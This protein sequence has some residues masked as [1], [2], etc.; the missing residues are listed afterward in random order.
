MKKKKTGLIITIVV[1]A[2]ILVVVGALAV[3]YF[4]TDMFKSEQELFWKYVSKNAQIT[5]V[6]S[7]EN[8][9]SQRQWK[10]NNSYTSQG[11]LSLSVIKEN[12]TQEIKVGTTAMHNQANGRTYSDA[13][14]YNGDE[15][16]LKLSY[17]NSG[18]V[19]ALQCK[20]IYEPYYIGVR[21]SNLK[22]FATNMGLSEEEIE[23]IPDSIP[24]N[25]T[26]NASK[27]TE[28]ESKYLSDTY[29][30]VLMNTIAK[31]RYV[32]VEK[33]NIIV[34]SQNYEAAGYQLTLTSDDLEQM[35]INV[36]TKAKDD[37]QTIAILNKLV[38]DEN[39]TEQINVQELIE[40][41]LE[42]IQ[43]DD[44]SV[45]LND[46]IGFVEE[47]LNDGIELIDEDL[48]DGIEPIDEDSNDMSEEVPET[49]DET[50]ETI[51]IVS[52][53]HVGD[54]I[55]KT[56]I[57]CVNE[58]ELTVD[59]DKSQENKKFA[60]IYGK[61]IEDAES[62]EEP[63]TMQLTM[64]KQNLSNMVTY[65]TS[66]IN[67]QN[68]YKIIMTTSLG[69]VIENKIENNSK[70]TILDNNKKIEASYYKTMQ[71]AS[72]DVEIQELTNSNAVIIN[73]Y[74]KD[75]LEN[76]FESL[77]DKSEQVLTSKME[78]LNIGLEDSDDSLYYIEGIT[79]SL[80]TVANANGVA[81]PV[82][83]VGVS[84]VAAINQIMQSMTET[85]TDAS[86][87]LEDTKIDTI[88]EIM[89]LT[90]SIIQFDSMAGEDFSNVDN[91]KTLLEE[92]FGDGYE[93][94]DLGN[95]SFNNTTKQL[96]GTITVKT[97]EKL[98]LV[99]FTNDTVVETVK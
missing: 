97:D 26:E 74:P 78:Q 8:E 94:T 69:N 71:Q 16:L 89:Q 43:S 55:F 31:E 81:Q 3:L 14:L 77:G 2:V 9:E 96:E 72:Q 25:V 4:M 12:G 19:Y 48:D 76:F 68:D 13:T 59:I 15:E 92:Q 56:E 84:L 45:E 37:E 82:G 62:T 34:N 20:D 90:Q 88:K 73:N 33:T 17:I 7:S 41:L 75:Q 22:E 36:L 35:V 49:R 87:A 57:N 38:Y 23:K 47:G 53:Y 80:L 50:E 52:V 6:I 28:E 99:D 93:I 65:T 66:I 18:D 85:F 98:Y 61:T 30:D 40:K 44:S 63:T 91:I 86:N 79:T 1:I 10:E 64:E 83:T 24:L 67:N 42:E 70:I 54:E 27:I 58:V 21:N 29:L 32:K 95:I 46:G 39:Q 11:N 5:E 51:I 60:A